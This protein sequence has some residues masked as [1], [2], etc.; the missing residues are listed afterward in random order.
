MIIQVLDELNF[1]VFDDEIEQLKVLVKE[2]M[3][4]ALKL[5]VPL[6]VEIGIGNNWLE[7]H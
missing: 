7:A 5:D 1:D 3:E 6:L 2:E 4:G